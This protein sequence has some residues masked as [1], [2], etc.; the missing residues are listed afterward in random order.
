MPPGRELDTNDLELRARKRHRND[1]RA[2]SRE[3]KA[4]AGLKTVQKWLS[5]RHVPVY[6]TR[7]SGATF[8]DDKKHIELNASLSRA[9]QLVFLLHE[10]G[11]ILVGKRERDER[12]G[13]AKILD[14]E[15]C[16]YS[17]IVDV[18]DEEFEAWARSAKLAERLGIEV[19]EDEWRKTKTWA[20]VSY[21]RWATKDAAYNDGDYS[22]MRSEPVGDSDRDD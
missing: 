4:I 12:Y 21:M 8:D 22:D 2:L 6:V 19:D 7:G 20:L 18:V 17:H 5:R 10:C 9:K 13:M 14:G 16:T 11:H 15:R 3:L 1:P